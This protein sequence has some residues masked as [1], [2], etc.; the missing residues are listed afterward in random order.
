MAWYDVMLTPFG[1]VVTVM[2]EQGLARVDFQEGQ[3]PCRI[4][5]DGS[6]PA[7]LSTVTTELTDYF[8]GT[9]KEFSI[10]C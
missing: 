10:R 9:R 4:E 3:R 1:P 5:P 2:D 8:S 6:G 7:R